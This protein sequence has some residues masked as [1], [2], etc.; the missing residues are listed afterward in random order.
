MVTN[1]ELGATYSITVKIAASDSTTDINDV[2]VNTFEMQLG[3][4][5]DTFVIYLGNTVEYDTAQYIRV[6]FNPVT[7]P[8]SLK[9][10]TGF[11]IYTMDNMQNK[12]DEM[13]GASYTTTTLNTF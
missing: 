4:Y 8:P 11:E 5:S 1:S 2:P 9:P 6:I 3:E 10:V 13:T 12:I 7:N